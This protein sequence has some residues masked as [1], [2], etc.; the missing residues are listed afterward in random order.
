MDLLH[1][2][3]LSEELSRNEFERKLGSRASKVVMNLRDKLFDEALKKK[4][5]ME[6]DVMV[7]RKKVGVGLT[8][9]TELRAWMGNRAKKFG[10][11]RF[12][13]PGAK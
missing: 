5:V 10:H 9:D 6:G 12:S 3:N 13:L 1:N 7:M 11:I 2:L 8:I 4:L